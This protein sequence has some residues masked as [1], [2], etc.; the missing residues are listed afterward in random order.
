MGEVQLLDFMK[1]SFLY[2]SI[3]AGAATLILVPVNLT[4][5]R[6]EIA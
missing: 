2:F 6:P 5:S 4:V 3:C 1:T